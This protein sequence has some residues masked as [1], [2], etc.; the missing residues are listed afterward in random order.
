M[1][2]SHQIHSCPDL[3]LWL[4]DMDLE[5]ALEP[6][7]IGQLQISGHHT[8]ALDLYFHLI[9]SPGNFSPG[10]CLRRAWYF[11]P[12]WSCGSVF[13]GF[14]FSLFGLCSKGKNGR[15]PSRASE[16]VRL[17]KMGRSSLLVPSPSPSPSASPFPI[18][19]SWICCP[20]RHA[21]ESAFPSEGRNHC[22]HAALL[23]SPPSQAGRCR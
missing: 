23:S 11:V 14:C 16:P 6:R 4:P 20:P 18:R 12:A 21:A 2:I 9:P 22:R 19:R 17:M 13:V 5:K 10:L 1:I 8:K 15:E 7:N 3:A